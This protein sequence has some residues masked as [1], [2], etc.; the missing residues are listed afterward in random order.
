MIP[1]PP[2]KK[3]GFSIVRTDIKN[4]KYII[5]TSSIAEK[6]EWMEALNDCIGRAGF[7]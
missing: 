4:E 5:L 2:D 3:N 7:V 6:T 1:A